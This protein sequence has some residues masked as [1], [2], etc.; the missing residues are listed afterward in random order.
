MSEATRKRPDL[1]GWV[2][3]G[4]LLLLWWLATAQEWVDTR[5][6]PVN[7]RAFLPYSDSY[8]AASK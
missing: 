8:P 6:G 7:T 3:P 1:R 4:V 2:V 5:L